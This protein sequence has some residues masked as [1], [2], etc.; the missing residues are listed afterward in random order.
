MGNDTFETGFNCMCAIYLRYLFK[1]KDKKACLFVYSETLLRN[2]VY[3]GIRG[4]LLFLYHNTM[5]KCM[6]FIWTITM[7]RIFIASRIKH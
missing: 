4:T 6:V 7:Q 5:P 1:L 2:V 3:S